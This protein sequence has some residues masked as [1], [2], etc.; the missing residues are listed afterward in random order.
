MTD[1]EEVQT[2]SPWTVNVEYNQHASMNKIVKTK[3]PIDVSTL[4]GLSWADAVA[5]L[6]EVLPIEAYK[7]IPGG[8]G[9]TDI[10]PAFLREY[11]TVVFGP[12]G[13]GWH[14]K[15]YPNDLVVEDT[16]KSGMGQYHATVTNLFLWVR[17]VLNGEIVVVEIPAV[18][19]SKNSNFDYAANGAITSAISKAASQLLWQLNV[20]KGILSHE[21]VAAAL[22]AVRAQED[23]ED[24][25]AVDGDELMDDAA[26][27]ALL[28][29]AE[30]A[31]YSIKIA[32]VRDALFN[33]LSLKPA[34]LN[35][36]TKA[37]GRIVYHYC[38][39]QIGLPKEKIDAAK[40]AGKAIAKIA[41]TEKLS[42][43]D[44]QARYRKA[45]LT[46]TAEDLGGKAKDAKK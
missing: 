11:L 29:V 10:N 1:K 9:L 30:K 6:T 7:G 28:T 20:Y 36:L 42:W 24:A 39:M 18:G 19:A 15:Y 46:K 22:E 27:A 17:L 3:L 4:T 38:N 40:E 21:N 25:E 41:V 44:A 8:A 33:A 5:K 32:K 12:V 34:K 13:I 16:G 43:E 2:G 26:V 45:E 31:G 35:E 14:F 37:N 23:L